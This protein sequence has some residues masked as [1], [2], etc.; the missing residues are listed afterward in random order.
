MKPPGFRRSTLAALALAWVTVHTLQVHDWLPGAF[1]AVVPF[2]VG[3]VGAPRRREAFW[4]ACVGG[5]VFF[6]TAEYFLGFYSRS[7]LAVMAFW[8]AATLAPVALGLRWLNGRWGW[9]LET[10]APAVFL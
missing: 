3:I 7:G 1:F 8:Q 5:W 9:P 4:F 6:M 10:L 2:A